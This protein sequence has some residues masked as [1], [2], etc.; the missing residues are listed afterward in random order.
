MYILDFYQKL[1]FLFTFDALMG[2]E[3]H[4]VGDKFIQVKEEILTL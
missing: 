2:L 3:N 1:E 4:D